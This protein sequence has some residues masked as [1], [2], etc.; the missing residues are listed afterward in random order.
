MRALVLGL[1]VVMAGC[2]TADMSSVNAPLNASTS[3]PR[4]ETASELGVDGDV[5]ALAFSGGGARAASFSYGVLLELRDR[6][7]AGG[8]RLID[9]VALVTAVSGGAI[10][11]AWLGQHGPDGLD[12]FR[13]AALDK[14]WAGKIN[15]S[16]VWPGNWGPLLGG[17][18]NDRG[19]LAGW[20]DKEVFGSAA[21]ADL[22]ARP[23]V[24]I[25]AT[26]LYTGAPFAFAP[27]YFEAICSDLSK[28]KVADAVA[29]SMAVPLAFRPTVVEAYP[30]SCGPM[31]AWVEKARADRSAPVLLRQTALAFEAYR[32]PAKM[33]YLHLVDGGVADNFGLSSLTT[34]REASGTPYGPFSARDAVKVRRVTFLVVNAER[35]FHA[36]WAMN[37]KGPGGVEAFGSM[38]D[39]LIDATKRNAYDAFRGMLKEWER[40]LVE[41]RCGL[42]ADEA[43]ALGA[44]PGWDCR[45]VGFRLDMVSFADLPPKDYEELGALATD[46][47]LPR[48]KID[49]L[50]A[51]GRAAVA[52]NALVREVGR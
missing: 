36:D 52:G 1:A 30:K 5:I 2:A 28:V 42:P 43:S 32:D 19:R 47:S 31:P 20:L 11:A 13:A 18:M 44:G 49:A 29:A 51:G 50:I 22:R 21:M 9:R 33:K 25:N 12:G 48:E 4:P 17:G 26:D 46:V 16:F 24:V 39:V 3:A 23:R 10:T 45:D 35:T 34:I 15:S 37:A 7:D 41:Y 38:V 27:A 40:E 14:D 6:R 8:T